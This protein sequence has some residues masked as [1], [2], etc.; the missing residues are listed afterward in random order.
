MAL[1]LPTTCTASLLAFGDNIIITSL[2]MR[3]TFGARFCRGSLRY[4]GYTV[5]RKISNK[6]R[7]ISGIRCMIHYHESSFAGIWERIMC[8]E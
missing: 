5:S 8:E 1:F 6:Y 4:V 3:K 7:P 2:L